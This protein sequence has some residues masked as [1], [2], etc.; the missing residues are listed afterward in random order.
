[1]QGKKWRFGYVSGGTEPNESK[2]SGRHLN[3]IGMYSCRVRPREVFN[4][5]HSE[6]RTE[7]IVVQFPQ[8]LSP[9]FPLLPL[10]VLS[11]FSP[12]G[13]RGS[14]TVRPEPPSDSLTDWLTCRLIFP[15]SLGRESRIRPLHHFATHHFLHCESLPFACSFYMADCFRYPAA[16]QLAF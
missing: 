7:S 8:P 13:F 11:P 2:T 4:K 6:W 12:R 9:P 15:H 10:L 3:W 14:S 5:C 1:M 16:H